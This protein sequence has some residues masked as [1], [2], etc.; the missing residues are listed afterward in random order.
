MKQ[1]RRNSV[2][3][4]WYELS[5]FVYAT[6]GIAAAMRSHGSLLMTASGVVLLLAAITIIG[7]RWIYRHDVVREADLDESQ[8]VTPITQDL[9]YDTHG[10]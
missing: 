7:L 9:F 10:K 5:P 1:R 6:A 8:Y 3:S 4:T 2:E